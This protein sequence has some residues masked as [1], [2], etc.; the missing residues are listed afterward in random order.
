M[1]LANCTEDDIVGHV[2]PFV[3]DNIKNTNWRSRDAAVMAF[4]K[5]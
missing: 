3:K 4:G 1:L 2:L 5:D